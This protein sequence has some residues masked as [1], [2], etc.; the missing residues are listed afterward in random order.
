MKRERP[1]SGQES[2]W[3]YP[4]PPALEPQAG[5]VRVQ[6]GGELIARSNRAW[7]VLE[8]SHPPT[9]YI[10]RDDVRMELL[11]PVP[12]AQSLCEWKGS[13][14]YFDL[15]VDGHRSARAAWTYARPTQ[16]FVAILGAI[17]FYPSRVDAAFIG[18]EQVTAQPG[19]FYGGW[20][21]TAVVGPFKG[22]P[23]TLGW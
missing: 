21:T 3:D 13:A 17:A 5:E 7:R 12:R 22:D 9:I 16:A 19:D 10:P 14:S 23:G 1:G 4:R 6:F 15:R 20:I 8:T 2:V 18:A 11:V